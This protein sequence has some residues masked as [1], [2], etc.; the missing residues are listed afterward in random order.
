M[1]LKY[2][3]RL[4]GT[5]NIDY[6]AILEFKGLRNQHGKILLYI[7]NHAEDFCAE[8][9]QNKVLLDMRKSY[10]HVLKKGD[11]VTVKAVNIFPGVCG[12]RNEP[13]W[14]HKPYLRITKIK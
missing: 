3:V 7:N 10:Q 8:Y 6:G 4:D 12:V 1:G 11:I 13:K 9:A 14:Y 2:T 5:Y